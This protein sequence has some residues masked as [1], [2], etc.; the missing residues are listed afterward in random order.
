MSKSEEWQVS[1]FS[2]EAL[3]PDQLREG[4]KSTGGIGGCPFAGFG[5]L[6]PSDLR[7]CASRQFAQQGWPEAQVDGVTLTKNPPKPPLGF[8]RLCPTQD[9]TVIL[10]A[11]RNVRNKRSTQGSCA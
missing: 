9:V 3:G 6:T 4:A 10:P 7:A 1:R 5:F 2:R 8:N 11:L